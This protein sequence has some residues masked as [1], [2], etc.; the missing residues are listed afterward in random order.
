M[1]LTQQAPGALSPVPLQEMAAHLR[2]A[3]GFSDDGAED[4][5]LELY[6]R[7]A[8]ATV[9]TRLARALI[10]RGYVL[11]IAHWNRDG[12]LTL[13]VG[14]VAQIDSIQ[15]ERPGSVITMAPEEWTLIPGESRQ[16][17]TGPHGCELRQIPHG[18]LAVLT[19]S[20]GYGESWNDVPDDLRQAVL[21]LASHY[22]E[23]RT[24]DVG[25]AGG[26]P[27]GVRSI[28]T[29]HQPMRL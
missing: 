6:L 9:E 14:P 13:P 17:L 3:H 20:A 7:N 26:I 11:K 2:L 22:Y 28:L 21:L 5:L 23:H 15:F 1:L 24:D 25:A 29:P 12:H 16:K 27:Q 4:A 18:A 19:F 8:T 10:H